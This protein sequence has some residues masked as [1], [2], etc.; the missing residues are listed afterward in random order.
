MDIDIFFSD[1]ILAN[2]MKIQTALMPPPPE[3]VEEIMEPLKKSEEMNAEKDEIQKNKNK[4]LRGKA[5]RISK[6]ENKEDGDEDL[7]EGEENIEDDRNEDVNDTRSLSAK[8][9]SDVDNSPENTIMKIDTSAPSKIDQKIIILFDRMTI[10]L[11]EVVPFK[12]ADLPE[13]E[14]IIDTHRSEVPHVN[15]LEMAFEGME[16]EFNNGKQQNLNLIMNR[17]YIKDLQKVRELKDGIEQDAKPLIPECFHMIM[18]N[19]EIEKEFDEGSSY[20]TMNTKQF[21]TE[22]F[23]SIRDDEESI[24]AQDHLANNLAQLKIS[25]KMFGPCTDVDFLFSNLRLIGKASAK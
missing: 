22:D 25:V 21:K 10:T 1:Y 13:Y 9:K 6:K 7:D 4:L 11:G 15:I 8:S 24:V 2:L 19:P 23:K 17:F 18:S 14:G 5:R 3:K 12:V 16:I 20:Y